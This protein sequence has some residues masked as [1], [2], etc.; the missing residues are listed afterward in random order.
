VTVGYHSPMP[1]ARTGVAGYSEALVRALAGLMRV[2]VN[3]SR[4]SD[5]ELWHLGNNAL[6]RP[7]LEKSLQRPGVAV[8]HDAVLHHFY[9]GG[10]DEERYLEEFVYN[11]GE[12]SRGLARELWKRRAHSAGDP[13]YF[14]YPM[15]RRVIEASRCVV[16]HNPMAAAFVREHVPEARV[17]EIPHLFDAPEPP[18]Q[19]VIARVRERFGPGAV[20]FG[21]FGHL[22]ESKRVLQVLHAFARVRRDHPHAW[23]VAAGEMASQ[24]LARA[25]APYWTNPGI[26]RLPYLS[27][28]EFWKWAHAVDVCINLRNPCAGETSGI[29]VRFAGIGRCVVATD[30]AEISRWPQDACLRVDAGLAEEEMLE[31]YLRW[32]CSTPAAVRE[33]GHRAAAHIAAHHAPARVAR[34]WVDLLERLA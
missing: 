24:D 12:W 6:H 28:S 1:P 11:Y 4:Y 22:R 21:L 30:G 25:A 8:L 23:L 32:A 3:S 20:V 31:A 19:F 16:V 17:E 26:V 29:M 10:N 14:R 27:E 9:L 5:V 13:E 15:L 18:P 2:T 34:L 7:I 33:I